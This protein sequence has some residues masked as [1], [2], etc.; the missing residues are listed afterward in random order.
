MRKRIRRNRFPY[1]ALPVA[2]VAV[3]LFLFYLKGKYE[4]NTEKRLTS[5]IESFPAR[6]LGEDNA[7]PDLERVIGW[8]RNIESSIPEIKRVVITWI[9]GDGREFVLY[10]VGGSNPPVGYD[11]L[12]TV[13]S[14]QGETRGQIGVV[15]NAWRINLPEYIT[16]GVVVLLLLV[17]PPVVA[18][19]AGQERRLMGVLAL[20]EEKNRELV[21]LEKMGLVGMLTA[22]IFHDIKKPILNIRAELDALPQSDVR[23][24]VEEQVD[25]FFR[26]IR[27]LNLEGFLRGSGSREEFLD[28]EEVIDSSLR[29]VHYEMGNVKVEKESLDGLPLVL[30]ARHRLVQAFSNLFL[31]AFQAMGGKGTLTI[32]GS[33]SS[34]NSRK[35]N[36]SVSDTG[37]GI[38]PDQI[39]RVFEPF[40]STGGEE[41]TGLGLYITQSI[42][43]DMGGS[44]SVESEV[45]KGAT[46]T[47]TL[48]AGEQE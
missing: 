37:R 21:H 42:V 47:V 3:S 32:K 46:F 8:G 12:P 38:P 22:N 27:D 6:Y 24:A 48:P 26:M 18:Q 23:N 33:A 30:S 5:S 44:L 39:H 13:L 1:Y 4:E 35:V 15:L 25:L 34:G 10:P 20:L 29:L 16:W 11:M 41:S 9:R 2:G 14:W 43:Q 40:F 45:G 28:L 19:T 17:I 36:V 7:L 31:N